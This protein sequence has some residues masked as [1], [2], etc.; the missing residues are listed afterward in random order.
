MRGGRVS[1]RRFRR[2]AAA[3]AALVVLGGPLTAPAYADGPG[4]ASAGD[5][6]RPAPDVQTVPWSLQR[7]LLDEL[8][9]GGKTTGS[10]VRVAVIDTG[11]D[12]GNPQLAGK[13]D[14]GPSLLF[15]KQ[16]NKPVDGTSKN[17]TVGHGTKVA[18]IIAAS[19]SDRTGFVG[20]APDARI[21][22][23]RQNDSE[24]NGDVS[25]LTAA[26]N[27]VVRNNTDVVKN[28]GPQTSLIRVINIS[29]DVRGA[30]DA[31]FGGYQELKAAIQA[32]E[33]ARIVVVASSGNDGKEG[34][35][36][37]GAFPTVLSVG[38]SDRNNERA[39][40][41][42][43]GSFVKVAAPGVEMLSTVPGGGQCVD[44]GT[45][46]AAPYVA[47]LAALLTGAHPDWTPAQ[48]RAWIEQSAQRTERGPNEFIGWGVVDPVKAVTK[49]PENPPS[50]A[51]PDAPVQLAS[52]PIVPAPVGLGETQADRDGRTATYV[53]GAG[54]LLVALLIGGGVVLRDHRR[55]SAD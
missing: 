48:V 26:I 1:G 24:G 14:A 17:D 52:A 37:P 47:G 33:D 16:N 21:Y 28:K 29:Q 11:V 9:Q 42:Q 32:A 22:A 12:D 6:P 50:E 25:S 8:W 31:H 55:K 7:L 38:A 53:V 41:S 23:I 36:Y 45:S 15:D 44:N 27:D 35:T 13:V 20:L 4:L 19:R 43:Y 54:A 46:F 18:G 39:P 51:V 2:T 5:C 40:F 3:L 34:D 10:G 49:A 30:G